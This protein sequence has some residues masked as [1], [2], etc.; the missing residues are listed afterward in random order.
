MGSAKS[1]MMAAKDKLLRVEALERCKQMLIC[2]QVNMHTARN[3]DKEAPV[4]KV[5]A[6][7]ANTMKMD[8]IMRKWVRRK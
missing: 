5:N 7:M 6:H 8:A 4:K 1:N 2:I 3:S